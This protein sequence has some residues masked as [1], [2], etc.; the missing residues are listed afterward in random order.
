MIGGFVVP[1]GIHKVVGLILAHY[2]QSIRSN[3]EKMSIISID[4]KDT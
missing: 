2:P 3:K 1:N 4:Y